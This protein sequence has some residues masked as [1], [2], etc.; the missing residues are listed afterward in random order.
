MRSVTDMQM[1][2][3]AV[4][5]HQAELPR[6]K[7]LRQMGGFAAAGL[8]ASTG[9]W[10]LAANPPARRI[11]SVGGALTEIIYA[12]NANNDLVAVDTTS[13]FPEVAR[14]LP[15]VGYAR[16]LSAEGVLGLAPTQVIATE[17]A[18]PPAV[19]RQLTA[20]GVPVTILAANHRFEGLL[21][22]VKRIGELTGRETQAAS[23]MQ[24]LQQEWT[25]ARAPILQREAQANSKPVRILFILA[26][27]P[28][29]IMV[30]GRDTSAQAMIDYVGAKNA[31]SPVS[32]SGFTGYKAMTPE[33]VIA[34]QPD[35]ILV[36]EQGVK[37]TGGTEAFLKMP[38]V[39]QTP[40]GRGHRVIAVE[41][42]LL[43]GFG[44]RLPQAV[45]LL[46]AA[47]TKA[48]LT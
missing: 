21:D 20:S 43:L 9:Q 31:I 37:A 5:E 15:S 8:F 32:G 41:A 6:R 16:T 4:S 24:N 38:G 47:I 33:A 39:E 30:A 23:M 44:P 22:R 40:A 19:L 14:K 28:A 36:T 26:H 25:R 2:A 42:M 45:S 3:G 11:V 12:L 13:L 17:D 29:Q 27:S 7:L 34:A 35:I 46:D 1:G 48:M 10:A 18:G